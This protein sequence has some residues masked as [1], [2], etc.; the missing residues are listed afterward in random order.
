VTVRA[1]VSRLR[2]AVGPLVEH[3]PYRLAAD[4][5]VEVRLPRPAARLLPSSTAPVVERLRAR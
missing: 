2:R 3:R 4:L 5:H 1:E